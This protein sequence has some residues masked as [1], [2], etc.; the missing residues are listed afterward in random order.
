VPSS[1]S[2]PI[3]Q[4]SRRRPPRDW[5]PETRRRWIE[6][7]IQAWA[8]EQIPLSRDDAYRASELPAHHSD[9]FDRLLVATS[10]NHDACIVTF[11]DAIHRYPVA[12]CW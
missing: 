4:A 1:G 7:Q 3:L 10:L 12:W 5:T 8:L 6:H 9:P 2:A 11:D